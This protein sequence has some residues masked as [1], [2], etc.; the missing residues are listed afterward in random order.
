MASRKTTQSG[1]FTRGYVTTRSN[2][3]GT[4]LDVG[5]F[6]PD[7][8]FVPAPRIRGYKDHGGLF[9]GYQWGYP[10]AQALQYLRWLNGGTPRDFEPEFL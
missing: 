9:G 3:D 6:H 1:R 7:G 10:R 5:F 8:S 4:V 2:R